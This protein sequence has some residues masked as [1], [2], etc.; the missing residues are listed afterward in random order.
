MMKDFLTFRRMLTPWLVNILFWLGTLAML[1][2]AIM[3]IFKGQ[4]WKGIEIIILGPI[5]VRIVCEI[6]IVFFRM[7]ET[8]TDIRNKP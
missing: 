5:L 4:Y 2:T 6:L 3:D 8:L 1:G 7:N